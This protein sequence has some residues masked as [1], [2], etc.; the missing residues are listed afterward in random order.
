MER[1]ETLA[2]FY[3]SGQ[4]NELHGGFNFVLINAPFEGRG[5]ADGR[6]GHGGAD[7]RGAWPIWTG[8]NHDVSRLATRWAGGDPAKVKVALLILLTLRGTPFLY[9]GDEIGLTD[10]AHQ[11]A[12]VLAHQVGTR[13]AVLQGPRRRTDPHALARWRRWWVQPARSAHLAA[14]GGPGAVQRGRPGGRPDVGA[15]ALPAGHHGKSAA[16]DDL[17]MGSY[18]SL[19]SPEGT[20]AYAHGEGTTVLLNMSAA[21]HLRRRGQQRDG[22]HR[23][24]P[25]G[26]ERGGR[27]DPR[28][29]ERR[30]RGAMSAPTPGAAGV[31]SYRL[32]GDMSA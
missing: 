19:I 7:P 23:A 13:L 24:H 26:V 1:L 27:A 11:R 21:R 8:S 4:D 9:Q 5:H 6:R 12:D 20:W 16:S 22:G 29:L 28:A 14:D 10:S 15:Q 25:G 32:T 30:R 2:Q 17:A 18:R 31:T 3:G